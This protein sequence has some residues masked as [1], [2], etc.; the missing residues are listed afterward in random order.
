MPS[1]FASNVLNIP[2]LSCRCETRIKNVI[3]G[4]SRSDYLLGMKIVAINMKIAEY[5]IHDFSGA[6]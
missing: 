2:Y 3:F 1:N 5:A 6:R 4:I